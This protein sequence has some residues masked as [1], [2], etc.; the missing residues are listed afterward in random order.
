MAALFS[1]DGRWLAAA[2]DQ[3]EVK[4]WEVQTGREAKSYKGRPGGMVEYVESATISR[5]GRWLVTEARGA[6]VELLEITSGDIHSFV[7]HK[8]QPG[9]FTFSPDGK[10]L[11][12]SGGQDNTIKLWRVPTS[13]GK[14][15]WPAEQ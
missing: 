3:K 8:G 4:V 14:T 15:I 13:T 2:N 11:A 6:V 10:L 7:G 1:P 12:S 9:A 5:D